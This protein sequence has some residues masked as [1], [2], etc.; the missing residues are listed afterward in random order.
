MVTVII[1]TVTPMQTYKTHTSRVLS[2]LERTTTPLNHH[3]TIP[4]HHTTTHT[5]SHFLCS[6]CSA[7]P[8]WIRTSDRQVCDTVKV[9]LVGMCVYHMRIGVSMCM[10]MAHMCLCMLH[11]CITCV[12]VWCIGTMHVVCVH[13][14]TPTNTFRHTLTRLHTLVHTIT[15]TLHTHT[16][17]HTHTRARVRPENTH[18]THPRVCVRSHT[19]TVTVCFTHSPAHDTTRFRCVCVS[20]LH[21]GGLE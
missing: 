15:H 6:T 5:P 16:V 10:C 21:F 12:L 20:V 9:V 3:T 2:P 4:H 7:A 18:I 17:P 14:P 19:V 8:I 1:Q 13:S 11:V